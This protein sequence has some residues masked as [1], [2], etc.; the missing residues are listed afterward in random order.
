MTFR[1]STTLAT[2][3]VLTVAEIKNA[4]EAFD[5]GDTNVFTTMDEIVTTVE[6]Y[7]IAMINQRSIEA[8]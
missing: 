4:V 5:R 7:R 8:A 3:A 2:I 6:A 1:D